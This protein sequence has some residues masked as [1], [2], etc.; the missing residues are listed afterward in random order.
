MKTIK[1]IL[2]E[3]SDLYYEQGIDYQEFK[4]FLI[5][6]IKYYEEAVVSELIITLKDDT[7]FIEQRIKEFWEK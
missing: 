3:Y 4:K 2:K 6:A 5:E 7:D 1:T